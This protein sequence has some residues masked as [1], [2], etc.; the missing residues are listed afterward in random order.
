MI[1]D[2]MN[3]PQEDVID[4]NIIAIIDAIIG[5]KGD[6]EDFDGASDVVFDI[7]EELVSSGEISEMPEIEVS[8]EEKNKW[9]ETSMPII[10]Q[11][12]QTA[13]HD[14]FLEEPD[15]DKNS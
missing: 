13:L 11:A 15:A 7:I 6:I 4:V 1:L 14:G 8:D 2:D 12:V 9:L 10:K 3:A 5:E